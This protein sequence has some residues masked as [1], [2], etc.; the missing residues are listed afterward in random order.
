MRKDEK[1]PQGFWV[2]AQCSC[3]YC[4]KSVWFKGLRQHQGSS[5]ACLAQQKKALN[6]LEVTE[7]WWQCPLCDCFTNSED[8]MANHFLKRHPTMGQ[9]ETRSF[10]A[11]K[12]NENKWYTPEKG[13]AS[14]SQG[15]QGKYHGQWWFP[16]KSGKPHT[17]SEGG[18]QRSDVW[19]P[20][21]SNRERDRRRD[22]REREDVA[23][24]ERS[25]IPRRQHPWRQQSRRTDGRG[26]EQG[27]PRDRDSRERPQ[28]NVVH[29]RDARGWRSRSP[30]E[31]SA[32]PSYSQAVTASTEAMRREGASQLVQQLRL[33]EGLRHWHPCSKPK[34]LSCEPVELLMFSLQDVQKH[35][36]D[37]FQKKKG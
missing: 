14:S 28:G 30:T 15:H 19:K 17:P 9:E 36:L 7:K 33:M 37:V 4:K 6:T 27:S 26:N 21:S 29:L 8:K 5:A 25:R 18:N 10:L 1:E 3:P 31:S 2:D 13:E 12:R 34:L 35:R 22:S 24:D 20:P 16:K 23:R 32:G 11:K